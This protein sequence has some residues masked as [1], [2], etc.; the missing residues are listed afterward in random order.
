MKEIRSVLA[1][2]STFVLEFAN[3]RNWK[4]ILRYLLGRQSWNPFSPEPVEFVKL[5]FDFHPHTMRRWL[6]EAG[7]T[8]ERQRTVSHYRLSLLKRLIPPSILAT[9]DGWV[10][11]TGNWLQFT[12][13]IFVQCTARGSEAKQDIQDVR[14]IF[15]C[16]VCKGEFDPDSDRFICQAG[17]RWAMRDGVYDF[18][19]QLKS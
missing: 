6:A 16:P 11:P 10:Q 3:K 15:R 1:P 8:V 2:Q 9:V 5:N 14:E 19:E 13:S 7:F 18:K 17:H 4:S 12:P